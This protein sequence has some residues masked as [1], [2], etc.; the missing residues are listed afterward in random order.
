VALPNF[1]VI[2]APKAGTTALHLA[3]A[4]HPGL[5]LSVIKEPKFFPS[6]GPRERSRRCVRAGGGASAIPSLL[7]EP[8]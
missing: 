7:F 4:G 1:V 8:E 5:Y 6:D 3:L 2:G